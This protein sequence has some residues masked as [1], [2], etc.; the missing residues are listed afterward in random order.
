MSRSQRE[1]WRE[2]HVK[3]ETFNRIHSDKPSGPIPGFVDFL[4]ER[5]LSP[6]RTKILDIGCGKGRNSIWLASQGYSVVGVDFVQE[7][8][9]EATKRN[10][11]RFKD[12]K[13][14]VV[15][16]TERWSY[17]DGTFDVITDC[18]STICVLNPGRQIAIAEAHRVLKP[19]GYYLFYGVSRT[20][21]VDKSP[22]PEPDSAIFPRTG[23][24]EK[25]YTEEELRSAYSDYRIVKLES[26]TGSDL[27]EGKEITYSM[28][29]G[30]FQRS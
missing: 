25:Q 8:I 29:V 5:G 22:G 30:V 21:F 14:E 7:A 11:G 9:D 23:K 6:E 12:L 20:P 2:E 18:N 17:G 4:K 3:Q 28:W 10:G 16:L 27:I 1:I 15:D 19:D 26:Q 24:F 13:F